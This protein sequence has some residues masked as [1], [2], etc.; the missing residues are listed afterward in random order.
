MSN[1]ILTSTFLKIQARLHSIAAGITGSSQEAEDVLQDSFCKLWNQRIGIS[2]ETSAA[3]LSYTVVRNSA[4]DV[5]RRNRTHITTPLDDRDFPDTS[6]LSDR[7]GENLLREI[8]DLCRSNL[9]PRQWEVFRLHDIEN[10]PYPEIA[11]R[12]GIS[13]ENARAILS[14]TRKAIRDIY[15]NKKL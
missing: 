4:I 11:D 1:S 3:R 15:R 5:V 14:R 9:T 7:S 12:L 13:Q 8:M 10:I 2:D 6:P